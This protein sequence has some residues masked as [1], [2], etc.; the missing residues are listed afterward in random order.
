MDYRKTVVF[1]AVTGFIALL[2]SCSTNEAIQFRYEAEK[3]FYQAE[4]LLSNTRI[5][6]ELINPQDMRAIATRFGEAL[7][8]CYQALE[9]I[10]SSSHPVEY[11][12]VQYVAYGASSRLAQLFFSFKRHDTC[13]TVLNRLLDKV[14][15]D[16]PQLL[17]TYLN[18]GQALQA[19]GLWDSA[20]TIYDY[21]LERFYPPLDDS[22]VVVRSLFNMPVELFRVVNMVGDSAQADER[23]QKALAYYG[24]FITEYPDE[25]VADA[26]H[27]NLARLYDETGQWEKEIG[28]L[29]TLLKSDMPERRKRN[30]EL[31]IADIYAAKL[32]EFQQALQRYNEILERLDPADTV[33]RP[34]VYFK[35]SM[36]KMDQ[37]EYSQARQILVDLK[38][39]YPSFYA[40]T[41]MAQ[42]AKARSFELEGKWNRAEVEYNYL[43]ENY[44]GSDEAMSALLYMPEY[45][46]EH[47]RRQEA[48]RW[49][50]QAEQYLDEIA[51]VS[52]GT[53]VEAK[54]L[55]YKADLYGKKGEWN[56][57]AEILLSLFDRYP[58][59][60]VGQRA[61]LK[62]SALYRRELNDQAAADSL[63]E[64]LKATI[65]HIE[66]SWES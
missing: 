53:L 41:P 9:R 49:Y 8:F 26:A 27:A 31:K 17:M 4:K 28:E 51:A 63:I 60:E 38:E 3:R 59:S 18:L 56:R 25:P 16:D 39:D 48:E 33:M 19:A 46:E 35:I 29:T 66:E 1:V 61:L 15:L 55:A 20:L 10:D 50:Q 32:K 62:A 40:S 5:K 6:P 34:L 43:I 65:A 12:E 13:I 47:G 11:R 44:R 64:V 58:D 36:V 2:V 7:E 42:Y 52:A 30:I 54:A 23:Y 22:G 37:G 21:A 45:L 57:S 24:R 14:Q